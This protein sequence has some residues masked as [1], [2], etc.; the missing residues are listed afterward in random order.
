MYD[1]FVTIIINGYISVNLC[2]I[3]FML[4]STK[5]SNE[6]SVY[7]IYALYS[8]HVVLL[9]NAALASSKLISNGSRGDVEADGVGADGDGFVLVSET[10]DFNAI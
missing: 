2:N 1:T 10:V 5:Y 8:S 9:L 7:T 6:Q 3:T 4:C